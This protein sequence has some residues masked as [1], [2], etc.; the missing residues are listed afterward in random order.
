MR[1]GKQP[2]PVRAAFLNCPGFTVGRFWVT[3]HFSVIP[4]VKE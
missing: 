1:M 4:G 3:C 2:S